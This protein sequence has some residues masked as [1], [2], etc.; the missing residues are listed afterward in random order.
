MS[1]GAGMRAYPRC[2]DL[3]LAEPGAGSSA[4]RPARP[5]DDG[6]E[7]GS[8][9][10]PYSV[11]FFCSRS[12]TGCQ[13][14]ITV[15]G[16]FD[17]Q[18]TEDFEEWLGGLDKI[19]RGR[20]VARLKKLQRGLWGDSKGVGGGVIELREAF[21]PGYRIYVVERG[22]RLVVVLAGGDKSSQTADIER[23]IGLAKET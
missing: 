7:A 22:N 15:L 6:P 13:R 4:R 16:A 8:R 9:V 3:G 20:I 21:G 5:S 17:V 14:S 19:V 2:Q 1:V 23:A 10:S 18:L 12:L 11:N